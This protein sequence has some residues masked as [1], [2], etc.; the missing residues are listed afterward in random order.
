[1]TVTF[2]VLG[3]WIL[4]D[5]ALAIALLILRRDRPEARA[6]LFAWVMQ[7]ERRRPRP[8]PVCRNDFQEIR[9]QPRCRQSAA[10]NN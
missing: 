8:T 4:L 10:Q 9:G 6:K 1:M 5:A 2:V 3:G 7:G